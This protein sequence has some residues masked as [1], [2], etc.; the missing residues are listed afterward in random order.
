VSFLPRDIS[1]IL[2]DF[3]LLVSH[4]SSSLQK[5]ATCEIG[6]SSG[7]LATYGGS[8]GFCG[9]RWMG[10]P[11]AAPSTSHRLACELPVGSEKAE[12]DLRWYPL[13]SNFTGRK[14]AKLVLLIIADKRGFF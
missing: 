11:Q 9:G 5:T 1:D 10:Q 7:H 14:T 3:F 2:G 12:R 6:T 8:L 4:L 13:S